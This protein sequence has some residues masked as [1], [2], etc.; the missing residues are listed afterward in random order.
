M[1]VHRVHAVPEKTRRGHQMPLIGITDGYEEPRGCWESNL[2]PLKEQLVLLTTKPSLQPPGM[3]FL[4]KVRHD[5]KC[6]PFE[7]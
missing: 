3:V 5:S 2:S 7:L 1:P 6:K 4:R